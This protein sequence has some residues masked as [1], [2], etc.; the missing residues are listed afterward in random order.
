MYVIAYPLFLSFLQKNR[1]D[2]ITYL[3]EVLPTKTAEQRG[4]FLQYTFDWY[5]WILERFQADY[6][7][8]KKNDELRRALDEG[9][10]PSLPPGH[11]ERKEVR[12][13]SNLFYDRTRE[14]DA[15]LICRP[16]NL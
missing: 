7:K 10:V 1:K 5:P 3:L 9:E 12:L 6:Y 14:T 13:L 8:R 2:M 15:D 4:I 11:V 16:S